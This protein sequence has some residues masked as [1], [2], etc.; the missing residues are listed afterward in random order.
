MHLKTKDIKIMVV[1]ESVFVKDL[2]TKSISLNGELIMDG[3]MVYKLIV[4]RIMKTT[5][6]EFATNVWQKI[7]QQIVILF[8]RKRMQTIEELMY[9]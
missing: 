5:L 9:G 7:G 3:K 2:E 8:P 1:V 4:L 6:V